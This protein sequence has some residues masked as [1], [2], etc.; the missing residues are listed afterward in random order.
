M[1][2]SVEGQKCPICD[3]YL[4]DNDDLVFCP[5]CGTPSQKNYSGTVFTGTG[6]TIKKCSGNCENCSGCG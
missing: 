5:E 2:I 3:A 1:G 4:F 6:K